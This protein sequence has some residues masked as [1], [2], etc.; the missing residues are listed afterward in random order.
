[1]NIVIYKIKYLV[2]CLFFLTSIWG[3]IAEAQNMDLDLSLSSKKESSK[4]DT[5]VVMCDWLSD[6]SMTGA[7]S[8][9]KGK[10]I[11]NAYTSNIG[12]T[13][14]GKIPGLTVLSSGGEPAN[15]FPS[16][17]I[18]GLGTYQNSAPLTY[19]DGFEMDIS[20]LKPDEIE[21]ISILKDAAALAPFGIKGANGVI[22]VTT[23]KGKEGKADVKISLSFGIQK[24]V[25]LPQFVEAVDYVQ[26]YNEAKSNDNGN[27]WTP[28]YSEAQ[29]NAYKNGNIGNLANY[30]LLYP[31]VNWHDE[32]LRSLAP[33]T[34]ANITSSGGNKS[35]QYFLLLGYQNTE[36]LYKATDSKRN[37]NS[38]ISHQ[39]INVRANVDIQLNKIFDASVRFAGVIQ[40]NYSPTDSTDI[41]WKNMSK[42]PA[43]AF[44][45]ST[46]LG[47][48]GTSIYPDNPK[49]S[50]LQK[51]YHLKHHR[52]FQAALTLGQNLD[53]ITKGLRLA[54][55]YSLYN[56]TGS[57]YYKER[58]YQRYQPYLV[59]DVEVNY[60]ITGNQNTD[61]EIKQSG[62]DLNSQISRQNV[63]LALTY[64]RSFGKHRATGSVI[65]D[66]DRYLIDGNNVEF[67]TRGFKGRFGYAFNARYFAEIGYAI[68]GTGDFPPGK[69]IG[70]FPAI[71]FAWVMSKESFFKENQLIDFLKLRASAGLAGNSDIGGARFAY[72][73]YYK[74]SISNGMFGLNGVA[75][76]G[77]L[78]EDTIANTNLTWEKS[79]KINLGI[80]SRLF[81]K[82]EL[83]LDLFYE[84]R[85]DILAQQNIL[86]TM[87]LLTGMENSGVV[88]NSG[89]ELGLNWC[90]KINQVSYY[91]N[92]TFSFARNKIEEMNEGPKAEDY[93]RRTGKP[94]NQP[95]ALEAY[96][97]FQS[98]EEINDPKTPKHTFAK[99]QPGDIRYMDQNNDNI[100][101]EN[102]IIALPASYSDIPEIV[103]GLS[104]GGE[105]RGFDLSI[106]GHGVANRTVFLSGVN[107]WAFQNNGNIPKWAV[108]RWAFYQEQGI[109]TRANATY[110]RLSLGQ[111]DNNWRESSFWK[112][113]GSYF[114]LSEI[115]IG[116]TFPLNLTKKA[117]IEKL[118][119]FIMGG[120]LLT[121]D[122][123]VHVD[124]V[125]DAY[126]P[127]L[128]NFS[129]GLNLIF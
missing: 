39:K 66:D 15:D 52:S 98:W 126:Y 102:D 50:V 2:F 48:G 117:Q 16:Y 27:I 54:E 75:A 60:H 40:N 6:L 122:H 84:R 71:S 53:F 89:F 34:N 1:M 20:L 112:K 118:R 80:D 17:R 33:T 49:A 69:N 116:Y 35:V 107:N 56:N 70:F 100:I 115:T 64:D 83:S 88:R 95:F 97:L 110:P 12:N 82:L 10:E 11:E 43:N 42:Y 127:S 128:K 30:N 85:Y 18:R 123:I 14:Y 38:N 109:D 13:L 73:Q 124:P 67:L 21:S 63:Q 108:N 93:L 104:I 99:V 129:I 62:N 25:R 36:G 9:I 41:I 51:G 57:Y 5:A 101:D 103:Y 87:G 96:G 77:T 91:I 23:K 32:V 92:P 58:D 59:S 24:P 61:F 45:V 68:N 125:S 44:P 86:A 55:S 111:N 114:R 94:I 19:V 81:N 120:N 29:I 37:I 74:K 47:W 105:Y 121:I 28:Q 22:W 7:I 3:E 72:Q 106:S 76:Q 31:N 79:L 119:L 113:N 46:P 90:D 4:G 26:L 65:Y 78:Y 8:S